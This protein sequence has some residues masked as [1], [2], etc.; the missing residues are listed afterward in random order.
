[1]SSIDYLLGIKTDN[2]VV[3]AADRAQF[4]SGIIMLSQGTRWG[5]KSDEHSDCDHSLL[6]LLMHF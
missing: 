3:L 1:M 2:F 5:K 6:T 4:L